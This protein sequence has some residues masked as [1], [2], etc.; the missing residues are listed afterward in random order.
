M[1]IQIRPWHELDLHE[2]ARL[3]CTAKQ[4]GP[5]PDEAAVERVVRWLGEQFAELPRTAVL[6][7]LGERLVGFRRRGNGSAARRAAYLPCYPLRQQ[8]HFT[9]SFG[10]TR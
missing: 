2:V 6:A 3:T 4:A 1:Q 5:Q 9:V 10:L 7:C 8:S